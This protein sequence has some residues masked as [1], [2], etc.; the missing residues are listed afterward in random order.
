MQININN[1]KFILLFSILFVILSLI[2]GLIIGGYIKT[3]REN[4]TD[5]QYSTEIQKFWG[6][7]V[8]SNLNPTLLSKEEFFNIYKQAINSIQNRNFEEFLNLISTQRSWRLNYKLINFLPFEN[9]MP[10]VKVEK[11]DQTQNFYDFAIANII[12]YAPL[13]DSIIVEEIEHIFNN[14]TDN[15]PMRYYN[16]EQGIDILIDQ[17][18]YK[19][20]VTLKCHSTETKYFNGNGSGN[21]VFVY[22][23]GHW[24]FDWQ[25]WYDNN[26]KVEFINYKEER[27]DV[28][29]AYIN[30]SV[31]P[32]VWIIEKKYTLDK[33]TINKGE[34]V[35]WSNVSGVIQSYIDSNDALNWYS[36]FMNGGNFYKMFNVPGIYKY[37]VVYAD[38]I[39]TGIIEVL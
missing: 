30:I 15:L 4:K 8:V 3:N 9:G 38:N 23:D 33:I 32:D 28:N 36:P 11:V 16:P 7:E 18:G 27:G 10:V 34:T 22:E 25:T 2:V 14:V 17:S 21:I 6:D 35:K 13:P 1:R 24:K 31:N 39:F 26:V 12:N 29:D 19:Y 5:N 20:L 37:Q